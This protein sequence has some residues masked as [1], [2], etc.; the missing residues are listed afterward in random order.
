MG[1]GEVAAPVAILLMEF[2]T[3][4]IEKKKNPRYL[5]R[6]CWSMSLS[7]GSGA[8]RILL[9]RSR[10]SSLWWTDT[11]GCMSKVR[12][13]IRAGEGLIVGWIIM[14]LLDMQGKR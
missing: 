2:Q 4:I 9:G 1:I 5:L 7:Y 13:I 10:R 12:G 14:S 3:K 6:T 8:L 11:M